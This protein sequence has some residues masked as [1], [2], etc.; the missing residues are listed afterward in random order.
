[1]ENK[2]FCICVLISVVLFF[3]N[4]NAQLLENDP[5]QTLTDT[6][7]TLD[8]SRVNTDVCWRIVP[9]IGG[10]QQPKS[11]K[12]KFTRFN[13]EGEMYLYLYTA[14]LPS[15]HRLVGKYIGSQ[16]DVDI[17][18]EIDLS[19]TKVLLIA[20]GTGN[21]DFLMTWDT[22]LESEVLSS[23]NMFYALLFVFL[24]PAGLVSLTSLPCCANAEKAKKTRCTLILFI[25]GMVL[26]IMFFLLVLTRSIAL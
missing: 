24:F 16:L 12:L 6:Y 18:A 7:G 22:P 5:C 13:F 1:M 15:D 10:N 14:S 23:L 21:R 25:V 26:G 4:I 3:H 17:P 19:T 11:M 2:T 9:D 20:Q 8:I